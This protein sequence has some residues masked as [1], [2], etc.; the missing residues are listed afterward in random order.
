M[1]S[2]S[3]SPPPCCSDWHPLVFKCALLPIILSVWSFQSCPRRRLNV[4][5]VYLESFKLNMRPASFPGT[6]PPALFKDI[7]AWW[8]KQMYVNANKPNAKS[9]VAKR[10]INVPIVEDRNSF[11]MRD[12]S[13]WGHGAGNHS[14]QWRPEHLQR[15]SRNENTR[16]YGYVYFIYNFHQ[17]SGVSPDFHLSLSAWGLRQAS[18]RRG[19]CRA[20]QWWSTE[21]IMWLFLLLFWDS[22]L[23]FDDKKNEAGDPLMLRN[24]CTSK[25]GTALFPMKYINDSECVLVA[26]ELFRKW[27]APLKQV[28]QL[29]CIFSQI[30]CFVLF[31][32]PMCP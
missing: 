5:T 6:P 25:F 23:T 11:C 8:K 18:S 21:E 29:C 13:P 4:L 10:K 16:I 32:W 7:K 3:V 9:T 14:I 26:C 2:E 24:F 1:L 30:V 12:P 28:K 22:F 17:T 31:L 19:L 27:C 20:A 15:W